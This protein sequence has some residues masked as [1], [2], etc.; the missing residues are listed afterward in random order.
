MTR[1]PILCMSLALLIGSAS[2]QERPDQH[3]HGGPMMGHG[4]PMM[5]GRPAPNLKSL[6][7]EMRVQAITYCGGTYRVAT[8]DGKAQEF[9]E[10]NL[11]FKTDSGPDGPAKG[12]PA[13]L[14][15]GM[16]GDRAQVIFAA[17]EEISASIKPQC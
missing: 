17:P 8:S 7:P 4:G 10:R 6:T 12:A 1:I 3:M 14:Q 15:A 2:A 16:M 13:I 11:R 5:G 9:W